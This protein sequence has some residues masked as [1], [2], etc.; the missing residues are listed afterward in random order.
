[1]KEHPIPFRPE[2][3]TAILENRK[4]MTRR[5]IRF[6]PYADEKFG[7]YPHECPYGRPGDRLWVRET[8]TNENCEEP[9]YRADGHKIDWS[10]KKI[11]WKPSR[12][13]PRWA[14]R[15]TLEILNLGVERL[16]EITEEDAR[17]EGII[18]T[19]IETSPGS[20]IFKPYAIEEFKHLW[21]SIYSKKGMGWE[22]NPWVWCISFRRIT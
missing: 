20:G 12:F 2:M 10:G 5:P 18:W 22:G 1:M 13:M 16:Q 7:A 17:A 15:I 19:Q 21:N 4:T 8:W 6:K 9:I 3:V 11:K 14:S